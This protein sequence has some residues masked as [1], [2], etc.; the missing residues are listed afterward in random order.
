MHIQTGDRDYLRRL[1]TTEW[2]L[3]EDG[4]RIQSPKLYVLENVWTMDSVQIDNSCIGVQL[5]Q[6]YR[7]SSR[8]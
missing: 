5:S 2:A 3:P 7:Y 4:Y 1:G 8:F 6:T